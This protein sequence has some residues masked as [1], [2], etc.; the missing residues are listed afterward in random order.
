MMPKIRAGFNIDVK[1]MPEARIA[2]ISLSSDKILCLFNRIYL[3][4][5]AKIIDGKAIAEQN[6]S[7][8]K[9]EIFERENE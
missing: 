6:L 8:L 4:M 2:L 3:A 5:T 7:K 9:T 1:L